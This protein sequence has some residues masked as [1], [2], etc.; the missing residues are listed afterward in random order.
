M[1]GSKASTTE[2]EKDNTGIYNRMVGKCPY[3]TAVMGGIPI[4]CVI[5]TGSQVSTVT[6]RKLPVKEAANF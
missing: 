3:V 1:N 2:E 5:D 4:S 6:V